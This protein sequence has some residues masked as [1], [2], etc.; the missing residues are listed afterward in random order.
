MVISLSA[1][2]AYNTDRLKYF[3]KKD[4]ENM[5]SRVDFHLKN[6]WL[7]PFLV[8]ISSALILL[9]IN[10][11]KLSI[12]ILYAGIFIAVIIYF[13]FVNISLYSSNNIF[14]AAL[15]PFYIGFIWSVITSFVPLIEIYTKKKDAVILLLLH[16]FLLFSAN[17][18][19]FDF[20]DKTGDL[21]TKKPNIH[22][23][24]GFTQYIFIILLLCVLDIFLVF[25]GV[26]K[27][28][29]VFLWYETI[30]LIFY[31]LLLPL[32]FIK[33]EFSEKF[34]LTAVDGILLVP[35]IFIFI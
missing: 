19:W 8:I 33:K 25:L 21:K 23:H 3:L 11:I 17:A 34:Y 9:F 30:P 29:P 10:N 28:I 16:R 18:L 2:A 4:K 6:S 7:A 24:I 13:F 22:L 35:Y 27:N 12:I 14:F 15:K 20:K 5:P 26:S 31:T 1:V 32:A